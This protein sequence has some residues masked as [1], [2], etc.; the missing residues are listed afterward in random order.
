MNIVL[1]LSS[2]LQ[3]ALACGGLACDGGFVGP[4][5]VTPIEQVGERIVFA[6]RGR[7]V[8]MHV[9]IAYEGPAERFAWIV[10]VP[11]VPVLFISTDELFWLLEPLTAPRWRE[12]LR[13]VGCERERSDDTDNGW[14]LDSDD[15]NTD[16]PVQIAS[17]AAVGPYETVVLRG[18]R[19]GDVAQ[20]L[21]DNDYLIPPDLEASLTPYVASGSWFVALRLQKDRDAGDLEPLGLR[22]PGTEPTIP[23]ILSRVAA[24]EDM[25]ITVWVFGNGRATPLGYR[26][27]EINEGALSWE[28]RDVGYA[29]ALKRAVDEAGGQAFVTE[30]AGP[31][32]GEGRIFWQGRYNVPMLRRQDSPGCLLAAIDQQGFPRG[33]KLDAILEA[34][35]PGSAEL[36]RTRGYGPLCGSLGPLDSG[37]D[38][39]NGVISEPVPEIQAVVDTLKEVFV[40]PADRAERVLSSSSVLTRM[41][42]VIS[43]A[44]M[45]VD[46]RFRVGD[47]KPWVPVQRTSTL[48]EDCNGDGVARVELPDGRILGRPTAAWLAQHGYAD[49]DELYAPLRMHAALRVADIGLDGTRTV[50][51]DHQDEIDAAIDTIN[52]ELGPAKVFGPLEDRTCGC[53]GAPGAGWAALLA[54]GAWRGR[55]ARGRIVLHAQPRRNR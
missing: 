13:R 31:V 8:E 32:L 21:S 34:W 26:D 30:Y 44:E 47:R 38:T 48:I 29:S 53:A 35:W 46:P 41:S 17:R 52:R 12:Q 7:D 16:A 50:L 42:T 2:L 40:D 54:V 6:V 43:P 37:Q 28:R 3:P 4:Q 5:M 55:R 11:E 15:S 49:L 23:L 36:L 27:V 25:P 33:D 20:W 1:L 10:P 9:Q 51:Q 22:Y 39:D 45:T 19:T 14:A 24:S 18:E